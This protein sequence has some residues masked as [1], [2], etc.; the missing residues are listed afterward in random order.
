MAAWLSVSCDV[1]DLVEK[2]DAEDARSVLEEVIELTRYP[3]PNIPD[4][5]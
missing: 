1:D 4:R 2:M 5:E 3:T